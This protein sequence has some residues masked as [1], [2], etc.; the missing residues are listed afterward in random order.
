MSRLNC[1]ARKLCWSCHQD[2]LNM[3][4][5]FIHW[6]TYFRN[7]VFIFLSERPAK[8]WIYLWKYFGPDWWRSSA[9][10]TRVLSYTDKCIGT[11]PKLLSPLLKNAKCSFPSECSC[12]I[13]HGSAWQTGTPELFRRVISLEESF[14]VRI[15]K[16]W[17][18]LPA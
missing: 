3:R 2:C 18:R 15:S 14:G 13:C 8:W 11:G 16:A 17:V 7:I 10:H 6:A 1:L 5:G 4:S 9:E 12:G